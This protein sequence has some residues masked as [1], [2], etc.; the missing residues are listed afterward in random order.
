[1]I[2]LSP[3][4]V[5]S[6]PTG[7]AGSASSRSSIRTVLLVEPRGEVYARLANDLRSVGFRTLRATSAA[8][9]LRFFS[10]CRCD[11]V[12]TSDHLPD[13]PGRFLCCRLRWSHPDAHIWLYGW[14]AGETPHERA[15]VK[16]ADRFILSDGN[17]WN[18]SD[19]L[20]ERLLSPCA[21]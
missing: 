15:A 14:D 13:V 18:L 12:I 20:V 21:A 6:E 7:L 17:V 19:H 3:H 1:M 4:F 2:A 11:L 8:D 9:A 5:D 16:M 10:R